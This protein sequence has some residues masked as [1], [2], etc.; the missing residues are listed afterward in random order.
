M[1]SE[2]ISPFWV[3]G[4]QPFSARMGSDNNANASASTLNSFQSTLPHGE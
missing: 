4:Y 2:R 1:K 3:G